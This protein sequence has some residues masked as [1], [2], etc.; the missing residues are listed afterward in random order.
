[1][2]NC[3]KATPLDPGP[4]YFFDQ[5]KPK[6]KTWNKRTCKAQFS[7]LQDTSGSN[8]R[9]EKKKKSKKLK[10]SQLFAVAASEKEDEFHSPSISQSFSVPKLSPNLNF[11]KVHLQKNLLEE[12][13]LIAP[14]ILCELGE[15]L[16]KYAE[17][18][19]TFPVGVENLMN[20]T[21]KDLTEDAHRYVSKASTCGQDKA[22]QGNSNFMTIVDLIGC[23]SRSCSR[24]ECHKE[25][26][27][28]KAEKDHHV[29]P[30]KSMEKIS[31]DNQNQE[32][33]LPVVIHFSLSS[34]ICFENGWIF[35]HPY[36]KLEILKWKTILSIAVKRLQVAIIQIKTEEAK[37]KKEGFNKQ[38][39]LRHYDDEP[40]SERGS[41]GD[42]SPPS[43]WQELL[44]RKPQM[45]VVREADPEMK[46]FH[47]A[48][49]DG[50]SLTYY[51]SGRLA[52]CQSY[53]DLPRG[54]MYTNI[55]SDLPN[56]VILGTFTPFGCGSISFPKRKITAV[57]FNQDGGMVI[58]KKGKIIREWMWPSKGKLDDPVEIRDQGFQ[59]QTIE[60]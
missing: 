29:T 15:T 28:V 46:K 34:K 8:H 40:E 55:F 57:M 53:S 56:Q 30:S 16:Q 22:L 13:K 35:Q 51:P 59:I 38:L 3:T 1:M 23:K 47:Y 14:E 54:G 45:P 33:S 18:N 48:L 31:F 24:I 50:S 9:L 52:I 32:S 19:I 49:V 60:E 39:I 43:F 11:S 26:H 12:Y 44:E 25:N 2:E 21:W 6:R 41:V 27:L 7:H 58:S 10:K 20:Y 17:C 36:S 37:L 42:P 5:L 4:V